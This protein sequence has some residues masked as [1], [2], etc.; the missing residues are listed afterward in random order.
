MT[1]ENVYSDSSG[2]DG[3]VLRGWRGGERERE[4][5]GDGQVSGMRKR[6]NKKKRMTKE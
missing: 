6:R 5:E 4:E 2:G 3:R 1:L